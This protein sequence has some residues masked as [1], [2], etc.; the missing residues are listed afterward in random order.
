MAAS[1]DLLDQPPPTARPVP[2]LTLPTLPTQQFASHKLRF[3]T[4]QSPDKRTSSR[5][6]AL[7]ADAQQGCEKNIRGAAVGG[8]RI[9]DKLRA[10]DLGLETFR[11]WID[12]SH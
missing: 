3:R 11:I 9:P 6:D 12:Y 8:A 4:R 5:S 2:P 10:R 1:K 7:K